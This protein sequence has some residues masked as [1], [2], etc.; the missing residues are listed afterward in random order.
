MGQILA[1]AAE[2]IDSSV[3][4][5]FYPGMRHMTDAI[6]QLA[7]VSKLKGKKSPLFSEFYN[8]VQATQAANIPC[9]PGLFSVAY[10]SH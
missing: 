10:K 1:W 4:P 3:R 2:G 6:G 8:V 7:G 9:C 5:E